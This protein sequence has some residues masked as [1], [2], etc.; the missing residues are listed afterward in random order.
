MEALKNYTKAQRK[1][2]NLDFMWK[3]MSLF[4]VLGKPTG[5]HFNSKLPHRAGRP[6][7]LSLKKELWV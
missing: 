4:F 6:N 2:T 1:K 5:I 3:N 7:A